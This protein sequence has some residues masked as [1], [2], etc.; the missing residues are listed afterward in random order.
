MQLTYQNMLDHLLKLS[1]EQLK[2]NATVYDAD[3]DEL[4]PV[5]CFAITGQ[6]DEQDVRPEDDVLDDQHPYLMMGL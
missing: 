6:E 4:H 3:N 5:N 2:M 1:P